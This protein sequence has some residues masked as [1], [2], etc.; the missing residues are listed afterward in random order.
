MGTLDDLGACIDTASLEPMGNQLRHNIL[1]LTIFIY[2]MTSTTY[3]ILVLGLQMVENPRLVVSI[4][5]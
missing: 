5:T 1:T 4:Y 2:M 3:N